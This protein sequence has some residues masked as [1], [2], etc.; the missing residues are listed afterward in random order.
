MKTSAQHDPPH[1]QSKCSGAQCVPLMRLLDSA[2]E[3][4]GCVGGAIDRRAVLECVDGGGGALN[5]TVDRR[6]QD[7]PPCNTARPCMTSC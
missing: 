5:R 3:R 6:Q 2:T 7:T 1:A 4:H